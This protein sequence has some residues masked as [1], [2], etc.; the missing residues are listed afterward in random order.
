MFFWKSEIKPLEAKYVPVG[1]AD[2]ATIDRDLVLLPDI[3]VE[4]VSR[5]AA[6]MLKPLFD[7]VWQSD[8]HSQSCNLD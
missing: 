4:D 3:L 1:L 7:A 8:G 6:A 5:H 2:R